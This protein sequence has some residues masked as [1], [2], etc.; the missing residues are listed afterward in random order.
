MTFYPQKRPYSSFENN[1]GQ[2]DGRTDGWT[3]GPTDLPTDRRT[4]PQTRCVV[5]S[6]KQAGF[7]DGSIGKGAVRKRQTAMSEIN[8][9]IGIQPLD[10]LESE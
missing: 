10:A 5:S 4:R 9:V 3:D 8:I 2:T 1:T 7:R 6:K